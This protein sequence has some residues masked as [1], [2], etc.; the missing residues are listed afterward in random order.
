MNR[1]MLSLFLLSS[2]LLLAENPQPYVPPCPPCPPCPTCAPPPSPA[3]SAAPSSTPAPPEPWLTGPLIVP[4]GT[5]YTWGEMYLEPYIYAT[6]NT[7]MYNSRWHVVETPNFFSL[8]GQVFSYFGLT[9]FMDFAIIPQFFYQT[10]KGKHSVKFA[11]LPLGFDI[12]FL[13]QTPGAVYPGIKLSIREIFPTGNYQRLN[14]KKLETDLT[15]LGS[16]STQLGLILYQVYHLGG[17][18]FLST[19]YSASYTI[20]TPI[21]VHGF[22]AYGGGYGTNGKVFGGNSFQGIIS[23][24]LAITRNWAFAIDNVYTHTDIVHFQG[25]PGTTTKGGTTAATVGLPSSEQLSFAPAIEYNWSA[26]LGLIA[27]CWFTAAGRNSTQFRSGIV[28]LSYAY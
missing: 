27:G 17:Y 7:G 3:A 18:V 10:T 24:E 2:N 14:P 20:A 13:N 26:D 21:H 8:S 11:D 25:T 28:A 19:Y 15:G 12:Q 23:F 4:S 16:Y 9:S 6:T 22:N 5:A 1:T